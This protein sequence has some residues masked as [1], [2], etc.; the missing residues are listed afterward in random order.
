MVEPDVEYIFQWKRSDEWDWENIG[1]ALPSPEEAIGH[2]ARLKE[3]L[4]EYE[5]R[6]VRITTE[7][8]L[9]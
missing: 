6:V 8:V 9:Q 4:P 5:W 1:K 3:R 7:I 2:F